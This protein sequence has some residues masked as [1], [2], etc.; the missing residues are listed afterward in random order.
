MTPP[1][2]GLLASPSVRRG[3]CGNTPLK[4]SSGQMALI[5]IEHNVP[6]A[7]LHPITVR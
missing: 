7:I 2:G 1:N 5:I 3:F 4:S 6:F